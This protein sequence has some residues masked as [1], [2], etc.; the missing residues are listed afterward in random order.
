[1]TSSTA[2]AVTTARD[3]RQPDDH[4]ARRPPHPH[5]WQRPTGVVVGKVARHV[6][7]TELVTRAPAGTPPPWPRMPEA[8]QSRGTTERG[9]DASTHESCD[10]RQSRRSFAK[11]AVA[12]RV[13]RLT[14]ECR[15]RG[16]SLR[17]S[18]TELVQQ[19]ISVRNV[20]S[21]AQNHD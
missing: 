3:Q 8:T 19:S 6:A 14:I 11:K 15:A 5:V 21:C 16:D 17:S 4:T 2:I 12:I 18:S 9:L 1:M 13:K 20:A 10:R 7:V